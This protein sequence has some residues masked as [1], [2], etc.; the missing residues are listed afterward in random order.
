VLAQVVVCLQFAT[1]I[2]TQ[3]AKMEPG[4]TH[5]PIYFDLETSG[6]CSLSNEILQIAAIVY[7]DVSSVSHL[8]LL[9][10][11]PNIQ[12]MCDSGCLSTTTTT[13]SNDGVER[14]EIT[15]SV[16]CLPK[17]KSISDNASRVNKLTFDPDTNQLEHNGNPVQAYDIE[18]CLEMFVNFLSYIAS[19]REIGFSERNLVLVAHNAKFDIRF[20]M[21]SIK[22]IPVLYNRF[23]S[24]TKFKISGFLDTF[25]FVRNEYYNAKI[26]K[27]EYLIKYFNCAP[28]IDTEDNHQHLHNAIYD[29]K[30]VAN[31]I[32]KAIVLERGDIFG[33]PS[34]S[35]MTRE[36]YNQVGFIRFSNAININL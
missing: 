32:H 1:I 19:K 33:I 11:Q 10:H 18:F 12:Q 31:V 35:T 24:Q 13:T 4:F 7:E 2:Y 6:L 17:L 25:S 3:L 26:F 28:E 5:K 34:L 16:Y 9:E 21:A 27:L 36:I 8:P 14:N 30:C 29:C 15:F 23:I 22:K 20:L